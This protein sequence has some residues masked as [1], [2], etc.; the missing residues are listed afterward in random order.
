MIIELE[1]SFSLGFRDHKL[2]NI[3]GFVVSTR[4]YR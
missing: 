1:M 3:Q 2:T 4:I